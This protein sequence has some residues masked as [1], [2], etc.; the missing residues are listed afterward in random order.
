MQGRGLSDWE[1]D[2]RKE[3]LFRGFARLLGA[4][5]RPVGG[6]A[7]SLCLILQSRHRGQLSQDFEKLFRS[8]LQNLKTSSNISYR[9]R[10]CSFKGF[11]DIHNPQLLFS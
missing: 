1:R 9:M 7:A 5:S 6:L 11:C 4:V 2:L 10:G 3:G 8:N